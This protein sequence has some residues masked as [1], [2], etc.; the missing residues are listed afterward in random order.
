ML[1]PTAFESFSTHAR[2]S[3]KEYLGSTGIQIWKPRL[4]L[5]FGHASTPRCSSAVRWRRTMR[6][7]SSC[8]V[9]GPGSTSI[10][11]HVGRSWAWPAEVHG[12]SSKAA[13]FAAHTSDGME[14]STA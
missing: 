3:S 2:V 6:R 11:A 9:S 7:R 10:S 4:P 8:E 1:A 12:W 5:V 14:S 13:R